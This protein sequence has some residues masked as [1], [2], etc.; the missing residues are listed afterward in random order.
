[1]IEYNAGNYSDG[2]GFVFD[3]SDFLTVNATNVYSCL[4]GRG[5]RKDHAGYKLL[6]QPYFDEPRKHSTEFSANYALA[7]SNAPLLCNV[8]KTGSDRW[9]P[10]KYG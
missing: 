6:P 4:M 2:S 8:L 1:V 3:G 9:N 5:L 7:K 10:F